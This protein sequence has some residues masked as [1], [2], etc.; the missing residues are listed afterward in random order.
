[1]IRLHKVKKVYNGNKEEVVA[2]KEINLEIEKGEIYGII[3]YSGAGKSTLIRLINMLEEPTEGEI[4]VDGRQMNRLSQ[5]ELRKARQ[6]VGMIF[7]HFNLLWS[8]TVFENIA[9]P[10]EIAGVPKEEINQRVNELIDLVGLTE[11]ANAYPSELSGGQKQRVGIARALANRP[12]VLLSDEATSAL[13]PKTTD[14]ILELLQEINRKMGITIILITHEMH[15]IQKIC[16][17][18]AVIDQGE[19][20]EEG[21]VLEVFTHPKQQIT[22]EFVKQVT[23]HMDT[24]E[25]IRQI[26]LEKGSY[27]LKCKFVGENANQ[28]IISRWVKTLDVEANI[29]EGNIQYVQGSSYGSLYIQVKTTVDKLNESIQF[30]SN[31]GVEVEVVENVVGTK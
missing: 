9:F 5:K 29:L 31:C 16:H 2:L 7:Q 26:P 20:V 12:K 17:K 6:E 14:S 11:R 23:E 30:L 15:V 21:P 24:E 8:R 22:K 19:I 28:P 25:T 1:M 18:V 13:D 10:L 3:G 27:I 4:W